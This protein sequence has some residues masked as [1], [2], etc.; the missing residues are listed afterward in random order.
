M[1]FDDGLAYD[2]ILGFEGLSDGLPEGKE[3]EWPTIRLARL[4]AEKRAI[5]KNNI[6]DEEEL[7]KEKALQMESMRRAMLVE[8]VAGIDDDL[9]EE[10]FDDL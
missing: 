7:A 3:D 4:L 6:H 2:K 10:D 5:D 1:L 9:D 8:S